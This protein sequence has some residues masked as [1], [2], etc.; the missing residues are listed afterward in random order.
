[1]GKR[2]EARR[3]SLGE[4]SLQR[5]VE[6]EEALVY[7]QEK[8]RASLYLRKRRSGVMG[9]PVI[10]IRDTGDDDSGE[11]KIGNGAESGRVQG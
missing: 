5:E 10:A 3:E 7:C 6:G 2:N 4:G 8:Q 9:E 1:M 11:I